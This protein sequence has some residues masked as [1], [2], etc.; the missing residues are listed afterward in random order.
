M[1][2]AGTPASCR[3]A[4][5]LAAVLLIACTGVGCTEGRAAGSDYGDPGLRLDGAFDTLD[6]L[7]REVTRA[8]T[9]GD[10]PGLEA[11][12][13]TEH[14]HNEVV[15][16]EL[17]ASD[18]AVNFPVDFA[19]SN[20]EARNHAALGRLMPMFAGVPLGYRGVECRGEAEP[21]ATFLVLTD[22]WVMFSRGDEGEVW[23]VQ[24]FE[25]VLV[26]G[27]G[28]KIFRYYD[29]EPRRYVTGVS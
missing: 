11:V 3:L 29:K 7:G 17:P 20:I 6:D 2:C 25:D 13:L 26:R 12:R 21:F 28:Y 22:C 14:E 24:A 10:R 4:R 16:P 8:L 19:W 1:R 27:R 18:P 5:P 15:W 23:Q 9:E